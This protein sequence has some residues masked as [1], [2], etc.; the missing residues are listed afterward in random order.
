MLA[1]HV[2]SRRFAN[3]IGVRPVQQRDRTRCTLVQASPNY[4]RI[5]ASVGHRHISEI[6]RQP[7]LAV[8]IAFLV[9]FVRWRL[10]RLV[11]GMA[12]M[13][14]MCQPDDRIGSDL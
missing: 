3:S 2:Y 4:R 5:Q 12:Y 8:T 10:K 7:G 11:N 14:P 13:P 1:F 9:A 6:V